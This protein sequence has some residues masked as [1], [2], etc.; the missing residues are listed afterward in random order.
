MAVEQSG[1]F[2]GEPSPFCRCTHLLPQSPAYASFLSFTSGG[3]QGTGPKPETKQNEEI[4]ASSCL[5]LITFFIVSTVA[6]CSLFY[7]SKSERG[8]YIL[9]FGM[10]DYQF[11]YYTVKERKILKCTVKSSLSAKALVNHCV[12]KC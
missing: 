11:L 1:L 5:P 8:V 12:Y 10:I 9:F 2:S 6:I 3:A 4:E 7:C